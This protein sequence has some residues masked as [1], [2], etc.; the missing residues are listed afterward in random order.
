M[1]TQ[2]KPDEAICG[3]RQVMAAVEALNAEIRGGARIMDQGDY[4][5]RHIQSQ[6]MAAEAG[7]KDR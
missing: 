5:A 7:G 2:S 1:N 4:I 6:N 3:K